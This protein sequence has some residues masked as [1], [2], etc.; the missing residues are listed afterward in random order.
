VVHIATT[1][2]QR[3]GNTA[4][5]TLDSQVALLYLFSSCYVS[6]L[7]GLASSCGWKSHPEDSGSSFIRTLVPINKT[8]KLNSVAVVRKRTMPTERPLLVGE[9]SANLCW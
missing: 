4:V 2:L 6:V 1:G 9:V 7:Y 8:K 3:V 5:E